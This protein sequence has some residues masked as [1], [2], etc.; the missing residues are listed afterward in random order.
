VAVGTTDFGNVLIS[1]LARGLLAVV[2]FAVGTGTHNLGQAVAMEAVE[3]VL[4]AC[5]GGTKE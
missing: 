1:R 3:L 4:E 2:F 5:G